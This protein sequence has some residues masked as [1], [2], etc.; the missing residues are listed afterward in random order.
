WNV[1]RNDGSPDRKKYLG[2]LTTCERKINPQT[3]EEYDF[4]INDNVNCLKKAYNENLAQKYIK[5]YLAKRATGY[6]E[7]KYYHP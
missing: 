1:V 6:E 4:H 5:E 7:Y 2:I 3:Q